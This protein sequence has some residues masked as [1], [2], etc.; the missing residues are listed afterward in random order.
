MMRGMNCKMVAEVALCFRMSGALI[1]RI[2]MPRAHLG[3]Q[4]RYHKR[5]NISSIKIYLGFPRVVS[6]L[7]I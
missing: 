6:G 4:Q 7:R 1:R 2:S 3:Y 5:S